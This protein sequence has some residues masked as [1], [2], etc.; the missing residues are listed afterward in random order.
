MNNIVISTIEKYALLE[1][2]DSVVVA[3]SGGADS[4]VLLDILNSIKEKYNLKLFV[5][6]LNHN[7][8]GAEAK[9][10]E[11]FCKILCK[12]YKLELFVKSSDVITLAQQQKISLELCGRN[13]RYKFFSEL[14]QKLNA[15]IATAHT[16]SDNAETLIYNITRGSSIKGLCSIPP[17]RDKIIRPL[18]ELSRSQVEA[19]CKEHKLNYVTDS[20]NLSDDYTRNKIRHNVIS[21]LRAIN[22]QFES[23]AGRLAENAREIAE[24]IESQTLVALQKCRCEYGYSCEK[25]GNLDKPILKNAID[26]LCKDIAGFQPESRHIDLIINVIKN[27]GAVNLSDEFVATAKQRVF[28]IAKTDFNYDNF[29]IA[30]PV[31][32]SRDL[33]FE[34]NKKI[35]SV[36]KYNSDTENRN[37]LS[38]DVLQSN[39]VF[40]TRKE[41]DRFTYPKRNVTKPLRKA[42][43]ENKIPA[44]QRDNLLVLA[45]D[46][47][48]LWCEHL[49]SSQQALSGNEEKILIDIKGG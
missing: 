46:S 30:L 44:E 43:N 5:A 42:L 38:A 24:Y 25:L 12:N 15:K 23:S 31:K 18:I 49:G 32:I 40:R 34:Y 33:C 14:S 39:A 6:H 41:G 27:G 3:L 47:T 26:M 20:T 10:D 28:R 11:E 8:R 22:P 45:V 21:Q 35:I 48:V 36:K 1:E 37:V 29:S 4:V 7:I 16:A 19:Y 13:E 2:G 17:K 9:R